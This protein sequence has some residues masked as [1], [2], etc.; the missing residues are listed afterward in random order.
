MYDS[1]LT[2]YGVY[3][4]KLTLI[5]LIL[6]FCTVAYAV[7][8]NMYLASPK[9]IQVIGKQVFLTFDLECSNEF[10]DEWAGNLIAVSDDEGDMSIALGIALSKES[11]QAG[12]A[13]EFTYKYSLSKTGMRQSDLKNGATFEPLNIAE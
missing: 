8:R 3:M 1:P 6:S 5:G 10:P 7:P 9:K 4:N 13:K 11:C 2:K 12:P